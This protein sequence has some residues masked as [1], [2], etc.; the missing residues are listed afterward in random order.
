MKK[1]TVG[2]P[3]IVSQST[4]EPI[5]HGGWQDPC[6][7]CKD[8]ILYVR[9][10]GVMD[11]YDFNGVYDKNPVF[12]SKDE[13]RTW[14]RTS[15][16]EWD[17]IGLELPNGDV[18]SFYADPTSK[19]KNIGNLP[20]LDPRR[21]GENIKLNNFV[22]CYTRE[23]LYPIFGDGIDRRI[24]AQRLKKGASE[25]VKEYC[26]LNYNRIAYHLLS[27]G[28]LSGF[29]PTSAPRTDTEGNIY[30]PLGGFYI[31]PNGEM[32]SDVKC[33]H[34]FRSADN[35]KSFDYLS[36][37][38][39][40]REYD[41][42]NA[43]EIE[44]FNECAFE[45]LSNGTFMLIMRSGSLSPYILG[46]KDRPAPKAFI[47]YS[48]DKGMTW[49]RPEIFYDYGVRPNSAKTAD[50]TVVMT[51][52]RPDVYIRV[53]ENKEATEWGD[54]IHVLPVPEKDYYNAYWEYTCSNN[55]V[56]L[57]DGNVLFLVYSDFTLKTKDGVRA[58]SIVVRKITVE[59]R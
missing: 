26:K 21:S 23:E 40:K 14:E 55:D 29:Y 58:K 5:R 48:Y 34:M 53:S 30:L 35:G 45:I 42:E 39:Y 36:T 16:S 19:W 8:K 20:P 15:N 54:V 44:G 31:L 1:I 56:C 6:I 3:V 18:V 25:P 37:V 28:M 47:T 24:Y 59:D 4:T 38:P 2:D 17:K 12:F 57:Y 46:S 27:N 7:K 32:G 51:S 43:F 50:G 10:N 52:G 9:F 49:T 33:I 41:D 11:N 22:G 13:G